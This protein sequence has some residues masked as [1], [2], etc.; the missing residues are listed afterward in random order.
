MRSCAVWAS[1]QSREEWHFLKIKICFYCTSINNTVPCSYLCLGV[2]R[3]V[4]HGEKSVNIT[5]TCFKVSV[6]CQSSGK[7]LYG[8]DQCL[9]MCLAVAVPDSPASSYLT[10]PLPEIT[11]LM[12][13]SSPEV[14][15]WAVSASP[16]DQLQFSSATPAMGMTAFSKEPDKQLGQWGCKLHM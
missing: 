5:C 1:F 16:G 13:H 12:L 2:F 14:P 15:S 9:L 6:N 10:A 3:T 7:E 4:L 8:S 11:D